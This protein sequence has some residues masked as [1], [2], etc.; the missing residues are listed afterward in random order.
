MH[1]KITISGD[2][3][4]KTSD[5]DVQ[6]LDSVS[7]MHISSCSNRWITSSA[8]SNDSSCDFNP[9][10]DSL[11]PVLRERRSF[12]FQT[13]LS[14]P[15]SSLI[16]KRGSFDSP[17]SSTRFKTA[18]CVAFALF[19]LCTYS[20]LHNLVLLRT[21]SD[22]S[23]NSKQRDNYQPSSF[24]QN[25]QNGVVQSLLMHHVD[26]SV[27]P[28]FI[29]IEDNEE[30]AIIQRRQ[31]L[32]KMTEYED[33][34][35]GKQQEHQRFQVFQFSNA[36][37]RHFLQGIESNDCFS[38]K[39]HSNTQQYYMQK[40]YVSLLWKYCS[41]YLYG[42]MYVDLSKV[43]LFHHPITLISSAHHRTASSNNN[44]INNNVLIVNSALKQV[45]ESFM[46]WNEV[47]SPLLL[48]VLDNLVGGMSYLDHQDLSTTKKQEITRRDFL[49]E[50]ILNTNN[51]GNTQFLEQRCYRE[52]GITY[53]ND[54]LRCEVFNPQTLQIPMLITDPLD[55][56]LPFFTP[57]HSTSSENCRTSNKHAHS[58]SDLAVI[59][60][61]ERTDQTR[62]ATR[63]S[64][65]CYKDTPTF[66]QMMLENDCLPSNRLCKSCLVLEGT[67]DKCRTLCTCYCNAICNPSFAP[68]RK[69]IKK[70]YSV[71]VPTQTQQFM[72]PRKIHQIWTDELPI[73]H[74]PK[75]S[76]VLNSF[77]HSKWGSHYLWDL[78]LDVP[79]FLKTHFPS[80]VL[81]AYNS[82][83]LPRFKSDLARYC[84]L[85]IHGG[86]YAEP[87]IILNV[88]LDNAIQM[89]IGFMAVV[90]NISR[91]MVRTFIR[92][93]IFS[94]DSVDMRMN[95]LYFSHLIALFQL[96]SRNKKN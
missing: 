85:L 13:S 62:N 31:I 86:V 94:G 1:N 2:L 8:T 69:L 24:Q 89:D 46:I 14:S 7:L 16:R 52:T 53:F 60:M 59:E 37:Q 67:C 36:D 21:V 35:H 74:Y 84:L 41:L 32:I 12:A 47:R 73:D 72:I 10:V 96:P 29:S 27:M 71:K 17:R 81:E 63:Q 95:Y 23:R 55:V 87:D 28:I 38:V 51:K 80:E 15:H 64:S 45:E 43:A 91:P 30:E 33:P 26:R 79:I 18:K 25:P 82:L 44:N 3:K 66:F 57:C 11:S 68:R 75:M 49:F 76:R 6:E 50:S 61:T 22:N 54:S 92:S 5:G 34:E 90:V 4:R 40:H 83:T 88:D 78:E 9:G 39:N 42:G 93:R 48:R 70:K 20:L 19:F 65:F 56:A 58:N 77:K